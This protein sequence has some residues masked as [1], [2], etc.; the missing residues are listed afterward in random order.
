VANENSAGVKDI[1]EFLLNIGQ[2]CRNW[3]K[4][5]FRDARIS[6][7]RS[8]KGLKKGEEKTYCVT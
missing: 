6:Y 4:H 2:V 8:I 3:G 7:W 1:E 5:F